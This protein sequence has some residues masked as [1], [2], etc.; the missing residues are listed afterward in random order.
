MALKPEANPFRLGFGLMR[1]PKNGDGSIDIPWVPLGLV[2]DQVVEAS[3][4]LTLATPTSPESMLRDPSP[5]E[6]LSAFISLKNLEL[7]TP[8]S[9]ALTDNTEKGVHMAKTSV[10]MIIWAV[11]INLFIT[12]SVYRY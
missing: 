6:A 12:L 8:V 4:A 3:W 2:W 9:S 11:L 7:T 10:N 5:F 1:L